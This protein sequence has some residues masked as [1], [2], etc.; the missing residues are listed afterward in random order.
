MASVLYEQLELESRLPIP[1]IEADVS[2]NCYRHFLDTRVHVPGDADV[3]QRQ[4][5]MWS[6]E[7]LLHSQRL[8]GY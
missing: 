1:I 4:Y 6:G 5:T 2:E 8:T 7:R 3:D